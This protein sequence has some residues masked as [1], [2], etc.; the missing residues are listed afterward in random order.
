M[1]NPDLST[2][3][4]WYNK[5]RDCHFPSG[6][7]HFLSGVEPVQVQETVENH[8]KS[9]LI[10]HFDPRKADSIFTEEGEVSSLSSFS[11]TDSSGLLHIPR[12]QSSVACWVSNAKSW[13]LKSGCE[14]EIASSGTCPR[15]AACRV[16]SLASSGA[17]R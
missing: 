7:F 10:K 11:S 9:L 3:S 13:G 2:F 5:L 6:C 1:Q 15:G 16:V 14:T 4:G 12:V 8:L 17:H